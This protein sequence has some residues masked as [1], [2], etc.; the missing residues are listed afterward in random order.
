MK[1]NNFSNPFPKFC[2]DI[3]SGCCYIF[4]TLNHRRHLVMFLVKAKIMT[5][6]KYR[7]VTTGEEIS[8]SRR[9]QLAS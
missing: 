3:I 7:S 2:A 4:L 6:S 9:L 5:V 1:E 8:S